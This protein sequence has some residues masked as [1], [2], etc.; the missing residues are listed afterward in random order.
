MPKRE[1][2]RSSRSRTQSWADNIPLGSLDQLLD[3]LQNPTH[4]GVPQD[5]S[6]LDPQ[7]PNAH[8]ISL[9]ESPGAST[10]GGRSQIASLG[11][12]PTAGS[13]SDSVDELAFHT[14]DAGSLWQLEQ[15]GT[16]IELRAPI[17]ESLAASDESEA[18]PQIA[19]ES[20][21]GDSIFSEPASNHGTISGA[22]N[23]TDKPSKNRPIQHTSARLDL[24][25]WQRIAPLAECLPHLNHIAPENGRH[26]DV[27]SIT[28]VDYYCG[29]NALYYRDTGN[30]YVHQRLTITGLRNKKELQDKL[31]RLSAV[32]DDGPT[33]GVRLVMVEDLCPDLIETLGAAFEIDPEF[34]AEHLNRS[35]YDDMDYDDAPPG[36][37]ETNGLMKPYCTFKWYRPVLQNPKVTKWRETPGSLL[38]KVD[39]NIIQLGASGQDGRASI[40]WYDS[41]LRSDGSRNEDRK[42][43]RAVVSTN[44]FRRSRT[45]SARPARLVP[46]IK[47]PSDGDKEHVN[48]RAS[49][50]TAWEEKATCFV[51]HGASAPIGR[52]LAILLS[53]KHPD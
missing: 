42:E 19:P 6:S 27:G 48:F 30:P 37:W 47:E 11:S 35:G 1:A 3:V 46:L 33:V 18:P 5:Q 4:P 31:R 20:I 24:D 45:L 14:A 50:P 53:S 32:T 40:T 49:T 51:Y 9:P 16:P 17:P 34:F 23:D 21:P 2:I 39:A 13:R 26:R 41:P 22:P 43:H 12:H 28:C 38:G 25:Y 52:L 44:I 36:H 8:L 29:S 10:L 7:R 15:A